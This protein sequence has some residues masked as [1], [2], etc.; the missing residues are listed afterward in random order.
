[1]REH[2]TGCNVSRWGGEEFLILSK[3][4]VGSS[5]FR[6]IEGLRAAVEGYDFE[7]EGTKIKV[8]ITCGLADFVPG[9]SIDAWVSEA[10]DKL[11]AGKGSG[12]NKVVR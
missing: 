10:D 5:G 11:Y 2:C 8:T 4:K 9:R 3:G 1:M 12:K 6:T 7:Y